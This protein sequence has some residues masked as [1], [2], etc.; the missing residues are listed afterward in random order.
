M[1]SKGSGR[2]NYAKRFR[3]H[4]D[5]IFSRQNGRQNSVRRRFDRYDSLLRFDLHNGFAKLDRITNLFQPA[6]DRG[7]R[8]RQVLIGHDDGNTGDSWFPG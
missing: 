1:L 4:D 8:D 7:F 5:G 6:N 3:Q 2:L